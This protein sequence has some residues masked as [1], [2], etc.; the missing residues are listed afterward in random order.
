M[1]RL[2]SGDMDCPGQRVLNQHANDRQTSERRA[3]APQLPP[4]HGLETLP[5]SDRSG[6]ADS[7]LK[8]ERFA[9]ALPLSLGFP[10]V[11]RG[12]PDHMLWS[13]QTTP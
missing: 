7:L 9:H 11:I 8:T 13:G 5:R 3:L 4:G 2:V 10:Q 6:Y 1:G 12:T